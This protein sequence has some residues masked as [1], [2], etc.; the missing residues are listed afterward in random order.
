MIV[1]STNSKMEINCISNFPIGS[2]IGSVDLLNHGNN[3]YH[4]MILYITIMNW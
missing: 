3:E 4:G 1:L 2:L